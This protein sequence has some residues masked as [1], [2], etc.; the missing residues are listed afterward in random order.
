M[1]DARKTDAVFRASL[2]FQ[3]LLPYS[4]K[5]VQFS[6]PALGYIHQHPFKRILH[7]H[8]KKVD[9]KHHS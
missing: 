1:S 7:K 8:K 5:Q 6:Y 2:K 4:M 3:F 9:R